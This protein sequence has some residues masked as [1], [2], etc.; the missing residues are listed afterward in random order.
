[1]DEDLRSPLAGPRDDATEGIDEGTDPGIGRPDQGP[2][3]L[4]RPEGGEGE[5]EQRLVGVAVPGVVGQVDEDLGWPRAPPGSA[6]ERGQDVLV[7]DHREERLRPEPEVGP[8]LPGGEGR[9]VREPA[10]DPGKGLDQGD[11]LA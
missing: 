7:A 6:D 1:A 3:R 2:P 4:D 8:A 5:M 10:A 9:A 11:P